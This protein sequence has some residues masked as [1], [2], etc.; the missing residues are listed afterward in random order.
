MSAAA[1]TDWGVFVNECG[2]F[3]HRGGADW[4]LTYHGRQADTGRIAQLALS[5]AGGHYHV[6]C[7]S[8]EDAG[9]LRDHM[10]SMGVHKSH[11]KVQ[12]LSAARATAEKRAKA[13]G[14]RAVRVREAVAAGL[15]AREA[16]P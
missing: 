13:S 15:K 4:W 5:I 10:V 2:I 9:W 12:R 3:A 1:P 14:E 11:L 16:T 6:A 7:D 8:E